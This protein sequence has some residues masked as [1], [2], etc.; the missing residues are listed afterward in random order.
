[1][2]PRRSAPTKVVVF[3]WPCGTLA[4]RRWPRGAR[5]CRRAILVLA[6]VSS[7]KTSLLGSRSNWPSN[8]AWRRV[9]I[10]GRSCSA[11][12]A[13]FFE[14]DLPTLEKAPDRGHAGGDPAPSQFGLQFRQ[15]DVGRLLIKLED[16][17]RIALDPTRPTVTPQRPGPDIAGLL[18]QGE[19]ANCA[20]GAH[21]EPRRR[22][23]AR[24]PRLNGLDHPLTQ[25]NRQRF[26]HACR[27][28]SPA[29]SLNQTFADL[30]I[31]IRFNQSGKCSS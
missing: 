8:Q 5:P 24:H 6:P 26:A 13:V 21:P 10:S 31:P 28:P 2:P 16:K 27:P 25:V 15:R 9:R 1:M 3:Q 12:C 14:R 17:R 7:M 23:P 20:G 22:L 29:C 19:P 18:H 30:G 4:R 11:A